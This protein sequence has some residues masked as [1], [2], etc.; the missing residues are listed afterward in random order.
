ML[1][2]KSVQMRH[3]GLIIQSRLFRKRSQQVDSSVHVGTFWFRESTGVAVSMERQ[4][5]D[6]SRHWPPRSAENLR[7]CGIFDASTGFITGLTQ[8]GVAEGFEIGNAL[9]TATDDL[10]GVYFVAQVL[11]MALT[12]A[13]L[14]MTFDAGDWCFCVMVPLLLAGCAL[15][16]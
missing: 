12:V 13:F 14:A 15:T 6:V 9:P 5:L 4:Q 2:D 11:V 10:T 1:A 3:L 16:P 8:F 7:Y